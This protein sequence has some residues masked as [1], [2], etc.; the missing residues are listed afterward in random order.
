MT[1][2]T[3]SE[4]GGE[5][6]RDEIP[7]DMRGSFRRILES[8]LPW[9]DECCE[10][11]DIEIERQ[12]HAQQQHSAA[13][14]AHDRRRVAGI[15]V[16]LRDLSWSDV[17]VGNRPEVLAAARRWAG[18][19]SPGLLLAGPVGVGKTWLA[20]A[21]AW[22]LLE[23]APLHWL[24]VPALFARLSLGYADDERQATVRVLAGS[25]GLVLDDVDKVRATDYAAEQLFC[26]IDNRVAAGAPLLITTNL[27]LGELAAK[28]PDPFGE[29]IVSR[30]AQHCEAFALDGHDRRLEGVASA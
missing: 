29:A 19:G 23:R 2:V 12:A 7:A 9:C 27:R 22:A 13:K 6:D 11:A 15:P 28:F 4:C 10:R 16:K 3:C 21:A 1:L 25:T 8:H 18:G 5:F 14:R 24:S 26:A 30:L 20:A 17:E